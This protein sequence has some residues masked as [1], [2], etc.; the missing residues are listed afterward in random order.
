MSNMP[1]RLLVFDVDGVLTE[2]EAR[3]LDLALFRQLAEINRR[4]RQD[5]A[6]PAATVCT[7]RPAPYAEVILQAIDGHVPAVYENGA[8]LYVP[9]EYR[10]LT[11]PSLDGVGALG[12]H[13]A[14]VRTRLANT[15]VRRGFAYFQPGKEYSLSLF[16]VDPQQT[17]LLQ[18][19]AVAALGDL[20]DG[21]DFMYSPS[22]LN[23]VPR[24]M[25]KWKGIEF[26]GSYSGYSPQEMLGV[27]DS[28]GDLPF[29]SNVGYSAAPA[30]ANEA[31]K[32]IVD[33]VSPQRASD[34]VRDIL[35]HFAIAG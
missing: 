3:S 21:V 6:S 14:E 7:G 27:G 12:G 26:L 11:H 20:C 29:L 1:I 15:L 13:V 22:C 35:R 24:G 28:D 32:E 17:S 10:F 5:P 16:A 30:N 9:Q 34:G 4:A 19:E 8:G 23:I 18:D 25:H 33:Y 2:G 31:V